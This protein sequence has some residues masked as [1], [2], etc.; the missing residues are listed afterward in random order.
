MANPPTGGPYAVDLTRVHVEGYQ[1][2]GIALNGTF[3]F[4]LDTHGGDQSLTFF[5][6]LLLGLVQDLAGTF[7]GFDEHIG[8]VLTRLAQGLGGFLL[9]QLELV[10]TAFTGGEAIG[11]QFPALFHCTH[12]WRPDILHREPDKQ[13]EA[14]HLADKRE[15]ID[16]H[17]ANS[18]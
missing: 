13:R 6:R 11:D 5:F 16:V 7:T 9:R 17:D 14:D 8:G 1:K 4:G 15:E 18:R 12:E 2:G 10:M 3:V